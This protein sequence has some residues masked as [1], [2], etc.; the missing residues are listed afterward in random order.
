[1]AENSIDKLSIDIQAKVSSDQNKLDKLTTSLEK[2]QSILNKDFGKLTE[3]TNK[4]S[5]IKD[6]DNLNTSANSINKLSKS[7]EKLKSI[8]FAGFNKKINSIV[9]SLAP[10]KS[11]DLG[12]GTAISSFSKFANSLEKINKIDTSSLSKKLQ[13]ITNALKPLND[14]M[15]RGGRVASNYAILL[16][17]T[18]GKMQNITKTANK[19]AV[20]AKRTTT[21]ISKFVGSMYIVRR[22]ASF[23][24]DMVVETASWTENLNLF[25][26][27]FGQDK[28][29]DALKW[30]QD[31]AQNFGFASNQLLKF[32]GLFKQ[33][34]TSLGIADDTGTE[35]SKTLTKLSLD[36]SSYYNVDLERTFATFQSAI[37]GGQTKGARQLFGVE[38][39]YQ[40]LD[41][42]LKTNDALKKY[43]VTAKQLTQDQKALLRSIQFLVAGQ[44][45]F[46]DMEKTINSTANQL[47]VFEGAL[48]NLKLALGDM[49]LAEPFQKMLTYINGIIIGLTDIIRAFVPVNK[50]VSFANQI[51]QVGELNEELEKTKGNLLSFDKFEALSSTETT[52]VGNIEITQALT[53]E[54]RK[55]QELYD[56]ITNAMTTAG[57]KA[58]EIAK[59]IRDWFIE[60]DIDGKFVGWTD[61]AR[62]LG[63]ALASIFGAKM[64]T[65][66]FNFFVKLTTGISTVSS[67]LKGLNGIITIISKHPIIAVI[68]VVLGL[69]IKLYTVNE[70]FRNSVNNLFSAFKPLFDTLFN[71]FN[72]LA[73][74]IMPIIEKR[75]NNIAKILTPL[76]DIVVGV[77][78]I[79]LPAIEPIID[80]VLTAIDVISVAVKAVIRL[81]VGGFMDAVN[82]IVNTI[83]KFINIIL[84]P[85]NEMIKAFGGKSILIPE[86]NW[87]LPDIYY[88]NGGIIDTRGGDALAVVN[89]YGSNELVYSNNARQVEVSNQQSLEQSF[90]SALLKY[91]NI[92]ADDK[93]KISVEI[94]DKSSFAEFTR[95]ITP[96]VLKEGRR[97]GML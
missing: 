80:F 92:T 31:L 71:L 34:S 22:M 39:A 18:N 88:A 3:L 20:S 75:L 95:K 96:N 76:I 59:K 62:Y 40:T 48:S 9:N 85:L 19:T 23:I 52:G 73:Q 7:L 84:T 4:L 12:N 6:L 93:A 28:W 5:S 41:Q 13:T 91:H 27:S 37:F 70:D 82:A 55:Q 97:I 64:V 42:I 36:F 30:T 46:G 47:R 8:S 78:D 66:I 86:I 53:E 65:S 26:N 54:L 57:N 72:K 94:E 74:R 83:I 79:I 2:L 1:M 16:N 44:N 45:A 38:V 60:V 77:L 89:E 51:T 35:L 43:G 10:L 68:S 11:L 56:S 81:T 25:A 49:V 61:K 67:G 69:M 63:I 14:E 58:T 17:S 15:L 50:E 33:L 24:S 87:Q 32:T 29:E 90:L 21:L